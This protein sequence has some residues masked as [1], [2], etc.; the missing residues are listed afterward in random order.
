MY[1]ILFFYF[2]CLDLEFWFLDVDGLALPTLPMLILR[3]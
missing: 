1:M 3:A 2:S